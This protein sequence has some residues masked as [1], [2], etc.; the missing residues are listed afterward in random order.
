MRL[1][2]ILFPGVWVHELAH[3][4]ACILGNVKVH[5]IHVESH[6][7]M[8][9]HDKTNARNAW[10]IALAPLL[11]GTILSILCVSAAKNAWET[12]VP[13]SLFMGWLGVSIGFHSIPSMEDALNIPEAIFRRARESMGGNRSFLGKLVK[14]LGYI[15][16]LPVSFVVVAVMWVVNISMFFRWAWT[17]GL[18]VIA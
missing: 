1:L 16:V 14:T 4:L 3:A 18:V 2:S 6:S 5:R 12:N 7:G 11:L 17:L 15:V 8:V 9:V 10:M 13:L